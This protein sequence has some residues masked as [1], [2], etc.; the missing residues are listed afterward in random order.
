MIDLDLDVVRFRDGRVEVL[1]EDEFG[2]HQAT[3]G[4][5]PHMI[6]QP[7]TTAQ[8]SSTSKRSTR[9]STVPASNG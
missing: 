9:R 7:A 4:Y 3:L 8:S 6:N 2:Q 5:P 1:D